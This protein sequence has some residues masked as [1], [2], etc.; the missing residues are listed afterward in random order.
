MRSR[1][2]SAAAPFYLQHRV[3]VLAENPMFVD[4]AGALLAPQ[5]QQARKELIALGKTRTAAGPAFIEADNK[6]QRLT[7]QLISK[8]EQVGLFITGISKPGMI[9][10]GMRDPVTGDRSGGYFTFSALNPNSLVNDPYWDWRKGE[11]QHVQKVAIQRGKWMRFDAPHLA[12]SRYREAMRVAGRI[13]GMR[14]GTGPLRVITDVPIMLG[15]LGVAD[16]TLAARVTSNI[17]DSAAYVTSPLMR[18]IARHSPDISGWREAVLDHGIDDPRMAESMVTYHN[19]LAGHVG[20][21]KRLSGPIHYREFI[22]HARNQY[23][24]A[25]I[26]E[27]GLSSGATRDELSTILGAEFDRSKSLKR[28]AS[29]IG[30]SADDATLRSRP[31]RIRPGESLTQLEVGPNRTRA[32]FN[33]TGA[34]PTDVSGVRTIIGSTRASLVD[35]KL[36]SKLGGGFTVDAMMA[37]GGLGARIEQYRLSTAVSRISMSNMPLE[38]KVAAQ[39]VFAK[40][41]G[42]STYQFDSSAGRQ[43][44]VSWSSVPEGKTPLEVIQMAERQIAATLFPGQDPTK[45]A[46][47][48]ARFKVPYQSRELTLRELLTPATKKIS[49]VDATVLGKHWG[50]SAEEIVKLRQER[51]TILHT[52]AANRTSQPGYTQGSR[53]VRM[54][55]RRLQ[56]MHDI[57]RPLLEDP[58][59]SPKVFKG[60]NGVERVAA[61]DAYR[62]RRMWTRLS[63]PGTARGRA[64]YDMAFEMS[65]HNNNSLRSV[66]SA[67][68]IFGIEEFAKQ[69]GQQQTTIPAGG[70]KPWDAKSNPLLFDKTGKPARGIKWVEQPEEISLQ[71]QDKVLRTKHVPV[72]PGAALGFRKN[73]TMYADRKLGLVEATLELQQALS[74]A[75]GKIDLEQIKVAAEKVI[76]RSATAFK[77]YSKKGFHTKIKGGQGALLPMGALRPGEIGVTMQH[78]V[79]MGATKSEIELARQGNL[80]GAFLTDPAF[81]QS[82]FRARRI[83]M[84]DAPRGVGAMPMFFLNPGDFRTVQRDSDADVGKLLFSKVHNKGFMAMF[85]AQGGME[86][87]ALGAEMPASKAIQVAPKDLM[88]HLLYGS[89][90]LAG[91]ATS[92]KERAAMAYARSRPQTVTPAAHTISSKAAQLISDIGGG[93]TLADLGVSEARPELGVAYER[94][95]Q[96]MANG[97]PEKGYH[98]S[99]TSEAFIYTALKKAEKGSAGAK[100]LEAYLEMGA[101]TRPTIGSKAWQSHVGALDKAASEMMKDVPLERALSSAERLQAVEA[102]GLTA[103]L[104]AG[105]A[106]PM[107]EGITSRRGVVRGGA[108]QNLATALRGVFSGRPELEASTILGQGLGDATQELQNAAAAAV[109]N[110]KTMAGK[111]T[112]TLTQLLKGAGQKLTEMWQNNRSIRWLAAAGAGIGIASSLLGGDPKPVAEPVMDGPDLPRDANVST[113]DMGGGAPNFQM[114]SAPIAPIQRPMG[115]RSHYRVSGVGPVGVDFGGMAEATYGTPW[116]PVVN[117]GSVID[118]A[119]GPKYREEIEREMRRQY[120]SS[121]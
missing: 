14:R 25:R 24:N 37:E 94:I 99:K 16:P 32:F 97:G 70:L 38:Q 115:V 58:R 17:G 86:A 85:R 113:P 106:R 90:E 78:M 67:D 28:K 65:A 15:A 89:G 21:G 3:K 92:A 13:E 29:I 51:M 91:F 100:F 110:M 5:I 36:T 54:T 39:E 96:L 41:L 80:T 57:L 31:I 1:L 74:P 84:I 69:Y 119:S 4:E 64:M 103:P 2:G 26:E 30:Y 8:A 35:T 83:K 117:S 46:L 47:A 114:F 52:T 77:K 109:G 105:G 104:M 12:H 19:R 71:T 33:R 44:G 121:F 7:Q 82:H 10:G 81:S 75:G 66:V 108:W 20:F 22:E 63:T 98:L 76:D 34:S 61:E 11:H 73:R 112:P 40:I 6:L 49:A 93:A 59:G 102:F 87:A 68:R 72:L 79:E 42:G 111:S 116:S 60:L 88:E 9:Q 55:Y 43:V 118:D 27:V 107:Q 62:A 50:L 120:R 18:A 23:I 53:A 45:A 48:E 95:R 101:S 56:G